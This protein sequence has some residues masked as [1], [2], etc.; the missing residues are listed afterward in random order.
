MRYITYDFKQRAKA[1]TSP[2]ALHRPFSRLLNNIYAPGTLATLYVRLKIL[3]L[4]RWI[5]RTTILN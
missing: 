3:Y 2:F 4:E 1:A 5:D